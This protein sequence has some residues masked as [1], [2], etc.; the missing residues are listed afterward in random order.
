[1]SYLH[2]LCSLWST[3]ALHRLTPVPLF[4]LPWLPAAPVP[5]TLRGRDD[6]M[7]PH[8]GGGID[9]ELPDP[10]LVVYLL[11]VVWPEGDLRSLGIDY[12]WV[13]DYVGL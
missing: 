10:M 9:M 2:Q 5:Y 8:G 11:W 12:V 13:I 4:Q 7:D 1:M 3:P 6:R